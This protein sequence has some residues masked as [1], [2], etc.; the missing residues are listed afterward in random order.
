M[1][2]EIVIDVRPELVAETFKRDVAEARGIAKKDADEAVNAGAMARADFLGFDLDDAENIKD[3]VCDLRDEAQRAIRFL[4][5]VPFFRAYIAIL[6][7]AYKTFDSLV[8]SKV[9]EAEK[10]GAPV[11]VRNFNNS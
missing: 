8:L 11:V 9:C 4:E 6:I 3:K 1:A 10:T 7:G 2:K 5:W